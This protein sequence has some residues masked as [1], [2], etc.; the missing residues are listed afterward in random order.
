[1]FV[2]KSS[3]SRNCNIDNQ[4]L[5]VTDFLLMPDRQ[6]DFS[7]LVITIERNVA[8][9]AKA[10]QPFFKVRLRLTNWPVKSRLQSDGID[11]CPRN[12]SCL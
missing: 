12:P 8:T 9:I 6:D 5:S 4:T 7:L 10:N 2:A 11:I 1:M 3:S